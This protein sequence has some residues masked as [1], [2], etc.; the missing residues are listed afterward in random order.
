M[1][2]YCIE[3]I[4][5]TL[6]C[7]VFALMHYNQCRAG[8]GFRFG[9]LTLR[10]MKALRG[11]AYDLFTGAILLNLAIQI[12]IYKDLFSRYRG[13]DIVAYAHASTG[14]VLAFSF[15]PLMVLF[16]LV[17][18]F[19][20]RRWLKLN[21]LG[22]LWALWTLSSIWYGLTQ[23]SDVMFEDPLNY[24]YVKL[25]CDRKVNPGHVWL[26]TV[27]VIMALLIPPCG[28]L[29]AGVY[30][31]L[32]GCSLERLF[33][34]PAVRRFRKR[35]ADIAPFALAAIGLVGM[36]GVLALLISVRFWLK[37]NGGGDDD[38]RSE[39][40]TGQIL[41]VTT[42]TPVVV[43]FWYIFI[44][45]CPGSFPQLASHNGPLMPMQL[46]PNAVWKGA[47]PR[48]MAW[49]AILTR[50]VALRSNRAS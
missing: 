13:E 32:Q 39:W 10:C 47:Y 31:I 17:S 35:A 12:G 16:P 15:F 44:C 45:E 40:T 2:S 3:A 18:L 29:L 9:P 42:W 24:G 33:K 4:L 48:V 6:Y 50:G 27:F 1:T 11:S 49:S 43:E 22:A 25:K 14:L 19:G 23:F 21:V 20:R 34:G 28:A 38:G 36:W 30:F 5:V 8:Q 37:P 7:A 46:V 41:A 26:I